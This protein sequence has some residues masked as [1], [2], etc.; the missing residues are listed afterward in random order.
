MKQDIWITRRRPGTGLTDTEEFLGVDSTVV[1]VM[2]GFLG[3]R[4]HG[5]EEIYINN[6]EIVEVVVKPAE[7]K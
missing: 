7:Q 4:F 2:P 1:H 6:N 5:R 3:L